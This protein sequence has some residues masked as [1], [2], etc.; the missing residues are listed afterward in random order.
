MGFDGIDINMGCPDPNVAKKGGGAALILRP[1]IAQEIIRKTRQGIGEWSEGR[2]YKDIDL[3]PQII[4]F[5]ENFKEKFNIK[6]PRRNLP[7]SVKTRI[8]Y[9]TIVTKDWMQTLLEVEPVNITVHGRTLKQLYSGGANWDEIAVAA[10]LAHTTETTLLG[11]GD[12]KS[13]E[14]AIERSKTYGTDGV[15]IGRGAWGNPWIFNNITPEVKQRFTTALE[16][17]EA[18]SRLL[19]R[20]HFLAM[21]KHLSWYCKGF[22]G[23]SNIRVQLTRVNN[24]EDVARVIKNVE[25]E[26]ISG[27]M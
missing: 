26:G 7:I 1:D 5:V 20:G 24:V 14:D 6:P 13:Y 21:R 9:D 23:A 12:V 4:E 10:E 2:S 27:I 18:F 17:A 15:L 19:P 3:K 11:N 16:H 22:D 8:G 25:A